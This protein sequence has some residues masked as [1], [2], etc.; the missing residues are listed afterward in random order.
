MKLAEYLRNKRKLIDSKL[1]GILPSGSYFPASLHKAMHYCIAGGK[2]IR[3][4]LCM[5][6]CKACGGGEKDAI[7]ASCAVE[8]IHTYSLIHDDLPCMDDDDYRRGRPSCYK[9]FDEAT[10]VLAA[11]RIVPLLRKRATRPGEPRRISLTTLF[12]L[13]WTT[14]RWEKNSAPLPISFY[15][16]TGKD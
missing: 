6:S 11:A 14:K 13:M 7:L 4:I 9:K 3:P 5:A 2:R 12:W 15:K 1:Q 10:A 16:M 8:L